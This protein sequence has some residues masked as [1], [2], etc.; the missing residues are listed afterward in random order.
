M[1]VA[2]ADAGGVALHVAQQAAPRVGQLAVALE[3]HPPLEEVRRRVDEHALRLEA[4]APG[5]SRFLLIV[6]E[7]LRRAGVDDEPH[8][9]SI[10]AHAE[11]DGGDDDVG[12][13]VEERVLIPAALVVGKPGVVRPGA[14][15]G[16]GQPRRQRIDLT[17]RRA[18]DDARLAAVT[19]EDVEQLALQIRAREDAVEEIRPVERADEL[20][21][22]DAG[23]A[24]LRC[25]AGR[26]RSRSP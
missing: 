20:D 14:D 5:S 16:L 26:G 25:R 1:P 9:G 3:H 23:R 7:R 13:L 10:D 2:A 4:V 6:F 21:V 22:V 15:A 19:R 17:P 8:V 11:G 12:V 24:A 18:V